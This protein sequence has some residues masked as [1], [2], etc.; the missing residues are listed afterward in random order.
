MAAGLL[1]MEDRVG[2]ILPGYEADI[3][4]VERDPLADIAALEDVLFVMSDGHVALDRL[5]FRPD[6]VRVP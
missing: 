6:P 5:E 2:R 1:D 3:V 4:I